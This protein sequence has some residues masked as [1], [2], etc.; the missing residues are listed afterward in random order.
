MAA[1]FLMSGF[2][3]PNMALAVSPESVTIGV[4]TGAGAVSIDTT[5]V[6][7]GGTGT[8]T[9][10]NAIS[11]SETAPG[12]ITAGTHTISLPSGWEFN[13]D[14]HITAMN[15]DGLILA[16]YNITPDLTSF[17]FTVNTPSTSTTTLMLGGMQVR[18]TV[19]DIADAN[20]EMTH[21]GVAI[22]GVIDGGLLGATSFGTLTTVPSTVIKVVFATE[23]GGAEYGSLLSPQPVVKTQDL[24]GNDSVVGLGA[25]KMVTLERTVGTGTLQGTVSID[26]G[27]S[28]GNGI[29]TF[30]NVTV[31]TF[32]EGKQLTASADSLTSAVSTDFE[33]TKKPLS[34]TITAPNKPYD[35]S[36]SATF[37]GSPT[38]V[39]TAFSDDLTIAGGPSTVVTFDNANAGLGKTVTATDLILNGASADNYTYDGTATGTADITQLEITI[40]PTAGQTKIYGEADTVF[41]YDFTPALIS[42]DVFTGVLSRVTNENVGTYAYTLG[43]LEDRLDNY[44]LTL[45]PETFGITQR[46]LTV[47]ATGVN[48]VYNATTDAT[49]TL[50][51]DKIP[52]DDVTFSY[53]SASFSDKTADNGKTVN[54]NGISIDGT[55]AG[56]YDLQ[57]TEAVTTANITK[58]PIT[59]T[60]NVNDKTYDG[61]ASA[62]YSGSNPRVA[63][64]VIGGDTVVVL[65]TGT[66]AFE[67]KH[68]GVDKT[69]NATGLTLGGGDAGNYEFDGTG[70]GTAI[71]NVRP[72]TVTATADSK[73]YDGTNTSDEVPV[74]TNTGELIS[75][76]IMGSDVADFTQTYDN[77]NIGTNKVLTAN[78]SVEDGNSGN[79]YEVTFVPV[80]IGEITQAP[81]TATV[82]V[83]KK[84]VVDGDV[85]ATITNIELNGVVVGDDVEILSQGTA[86]FADAAVGNGK[87]VTA[88]GVTITGDDSGNYDFSGEATGTGDILVVPTVVYVDDDW[89]GKDAWDDMDGPAT[90]F[91]YDAFATIQEAVDAI[92]DGGTITVETG[93]Y[94]ENQI[95]IDKPLT[96][97][98]DGYATTIID[99]GGTST[100]GL[101]KIT[102]SSGTVI[103]S[104]FTIQNTNNSDDHGHGI[105]VDNGGVSGVDV[106]LLNNAIKNVG[107]V[108]IRVNDANSVQIEG[109]TISSLYSSA[110]V[111]PNGIQVGWPNGSG[112][113]GTIKSN[114]I[115]GSSWVNYNAGLGYDGDTTTSA[116]ILIMDATAALEISDNIIHNNNVGIDIEAGASSKIENNDIHD[117]AYGVVL[118]NQNP[119]INNNKIENNTTSGVFRT[120][121]G[122]LSGTVSATNNWWGT[123]VLSTVDDKTNGTI[124][125]EPYYVDVEMS[126]LSD[127]PISTVRVDDNW[128]D[129]DMMPDGYYFGYNAFSTIQEGIDAIDVSGTVNVADGT[130]DLTSRIDVNKA[131]IIVGNVATPASV[132]INAPLA[133]GTQHGQNSVFMIISD[134][135]TIQGFRIQGALHTGAAQNAG[136]YVDD[137]RLVTNPGLSN[138]TISDNE[139]TNN[140]WGIFVHNIKDS[141]ISDNKVYGNKSTATV[142]MEYDAGS[143][144][145]V[146]GRAEDSNHTHNLTIDNNQVYSNETDGIRVDVSSDVGAS[147]WINDLAITISNNIIY[148]NGRTI[149]GADKYIGIKSAGI[150][151]GVTVS[152][153]EIYGH[154]MSA[155]PSANNQ[156]AGIWIAASNDWGISNNN[157]RD[158]TNGIYFLASAAVAG[159]GSHIITNNDIHVNVRGISI[160]DGSEAIAN[161]NSIYSNDSTAFSGIGFAPY[162][163]YN[164]G[165]TSFDATQNWW[166]DISGPTHASNTG[167]IGDAVGDDVAFRPWRILND[168]TYTVD[169]TGPTP[170]ITSSAGSLTNDSPIPFSLNFGEV[171]TGFELG[172]ITVGNGTASDLVFTGTNYTFNITPTGEGTVTASIA[173]EKVWD[174]SGNYNAGS[175]TSSVEYDH[176]AP[177]LTS[178]S[179][180]SSNTTHTLAKVDDVVTVTF[181]SDE[182]IQTPTVT[183]AGN[184]ATVSGANKNWTA[185]YVMTSDDT[186]GVVP[187]TIN[188]SDLAGNDGT[189]VSVVSEDGGSVTFDKTAPEISIDSP[190][191]DARVNGDAVIEFTN[192]SDSTS[193]V[194]ECSVDNSN[195]HACTTGVTTLGDLAEFAGLGQGAL[196]LYLRDTDTAGNV[197]TTQIALVKDTTAPTITS[198]MPSINAVNVDTDTIT[199]VFDGA[200]NVSAGQITL[201][202]VKP[203]TIG[204]NG[205]NTITL[206]GLALESNTVY[207]VT[208]TS[209]V[210][211]LAGNPIAGAYSWSFTT[212]TLYSISLNADSGGWNLIS[213]P[214]V[215]TSTNISTVLGGASSAIN[216]VWTYDPTNVNANAENGGWFVYYP[217]NEELSSSLST[218]T[219]GY[220]YWISVTS[221]TTISGSGSLLTKGPTTPPSVDLADGWNLVGYYQIPGESSSNMTDAFKS[222][223]TAGAGYTSLFGFNNAS[224]TSTNVDVI[225]PGDGFWISVSPTGGKNYTPSNL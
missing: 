35:G 38:P 155:V 89:A 165:T 206:S 4:A 134:D 203:F 55:K 10:L 222:I 18:P 148:N 210:E 6:S 77:K 2:F 190:D 82:T 12:Q 132:V 130:Y 184:S 17:S 213:L 194:A 154:A 44:S 46:P 145:V 97:Q 128:N 207:T 117:N 86:T 217:N 149:L 25:S 67:N 99:G 102:V 16:S 88:T 108:G 32:G 107:P 129:G 177:T 197:G 140:G 161:N 53:T 119:S 92:E 163:I 124:D 156:S 57:N 103:I 34:A 211:D 45:V 27:T 20:G 142:D 131:V 71:I 133:G 58:K 54:V 110:A 43:T 202:P 122:S 160:D 208:V 65:N 94:N 30:T 87:V 49:I 199:I 118:W 51:S 50:S 224:G 23:P 166:G 85:S 26:I 183:I 158:N 36:N 15:G 56:N 185:T 225:L 191:E 215:P 189:A 192:D 5:L 113:I 187:F 152:G 167:A 223:G 48:K 21:S 218:M 8:Y 120:T 84:V 33:I 205:T 111:V 19:T 186:E 175:N 127:E 24:F 178:I 201:S 90:Y 22:A 62:T 114:E 169:A 66:K 188:F 126:I 153:N 70:S 214:I 138:I 41:T 204:G 75:G 182:D 173:A 14:A 150:S 31:D 159:S 121:L 143:G 209:D 109:N 112:V 69:V 137:P 193:T 81:L 219:A 40:T 73:T 195:W 72:I 83:Q 147:S 39:G 125:F 105:N 144:I 63:N 42:P 180:S 47:T 196:T 37:T 216:A 64:D 136:I 198:H 13:R 151:R 172:D 123:A 170:V 174:A 3:A 116:G 9:S 115:S 181:V 157:I 221:D 164:R 98:G 78:G 141:T 100:G 29:A 162:G 79:N 74:I 59:V 11:I 200:V 60:I 179:I 146:Y 212:A 1:T 68:A 52:E 171:V 104:G 106:K 176:V 93:T 7:L 135:V 76:P 139:L 28:A 168:L 61:D 220:G 91:G 95:L 101:V 96:L 80:A